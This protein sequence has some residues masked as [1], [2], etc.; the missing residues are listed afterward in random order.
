VAK[1][2]GRRILRRSTNR[3]EDNIKMVF[4]EME[5]GDG[6]D[7]LAQGRNRWRAFAYAVVSLRFTEMCRE[8][9]EYLK[10]C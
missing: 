8:F 10:T 7:Y 1:L 5:W 4:Q 6:L 2:E 9:L 3:W